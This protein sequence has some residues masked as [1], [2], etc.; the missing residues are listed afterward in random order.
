MSFFETGHNFVHSG[1]VAAAMDGTINPMELDDPQN[2]AA[3]SQQQQQGG[4]NDSEGEGDDLRPG[5]ADGLSLA[6]VTALSVDTCTDSSQ[7][8]SEDDSEAERLVR[9]GLLHVSLYT[10]LC[11]SWLFYH[12]LACPYYC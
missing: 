1:P 11:L 7:E 10:R 8:E 9:E 4:Q 3:Q 6:F 12:T 5:A 2:T